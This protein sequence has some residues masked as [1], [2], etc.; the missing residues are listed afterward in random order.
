MSSAAAT[1]R[2]TELRRQLK[3]WEREFAAAN[4]GRKADRSDIKAN[5]AIGTGMNNYYPEA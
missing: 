5:A 3:D 2:A 1:D 4:D